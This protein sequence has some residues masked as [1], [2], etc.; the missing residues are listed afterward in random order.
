MKA[1]PVNAKAIIFDL[2]GTLIDSAPDIAAAVNLY[3]ETRG[4]GPLAPDQITEFIGNGPRQLVADVLAHVGLPVDEAAVDEALTAYLDNYS[5]RP[6]ALT[7]FYSNVREDL[8]KLRD[9]GF[10]L[11]ICTNKTHA[12]TQKILALLGIDYLFE[13]AL[14]ADAVEQSKPHP[15][16]LSAVWSA[17]GLGP[18]DIVYVGDSNVDKLTAQRAGV[19]FFAVSWGAGGNV[20]VEPGFRLQ[21]LTDIVRY[22]EMAHD[23]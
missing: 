4:R 6:A 23:D 15:G 16:H 3:L 21:R 9:A 10:R 8:L 19:A 11:G 20:E 2:D 18:S 5:Q 14:G 7:E 22:I 12:L 1:P 17:M 13:A